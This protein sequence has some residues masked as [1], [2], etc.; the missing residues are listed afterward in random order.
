M[1]SKITLEVK[2]N[3]LYV[4]YLYKGTK[5]LFSTGIEISKDFCDKKQNLIFPDYPD[6][7]KL[8]YQI[9]VI[10]NKILH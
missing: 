3:H 7:P 5:T 10:T 2:N 1:L 6:A 8:N 4:K 9:S